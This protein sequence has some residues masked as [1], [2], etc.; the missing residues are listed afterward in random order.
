MANERQGNDQQLVEDYLQN[1]GITVAT[2]R[3]VT[4]DFVGRIF[5]ISVSLA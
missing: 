5:R 3:P 1:H 4:D 2:V